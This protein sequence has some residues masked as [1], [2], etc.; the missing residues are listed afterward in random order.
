M[1]ISRSKIK[2]DFKKSHDS[3]LFDKNS[4]K[5][6]LDLMSMYSSLP[7]GYNHPIFKSEEFTSEINNIAQIKNCNCEFVSD[8]QEEFVEMFKNFINTN[9]DF[10]YD[11]FHF[12]ST[13]ALAIEFAIKAAIDISKK[14][15]G[16]IVSFK[17]SFHGI[18]AYGNIV[19][20][21]VSGTKKRLEGFFG[22]NFWPQ[23][24]SLEELENIIANNKDSISGILIEPIQCTNGDLYFPEGFLDKVFEIAAKNNILSI[25]DEIQTGFGTTGKIWFTENK[26]DIIVFGKKSQVSGFALNSDLGISLNPNRYCITWDGDLI[27]MVRCKYIIKTII[28]DNLL[29]NIIPINEYMISELNKMP[30]T[31]NPRGKGFIMA[32]DL[33][34]SIERDRLYTA[35]LSN[36]LL[37]NTAGEN[38]IRLRPNLNFSLEEA[39]EC[40]QIIKKSFNE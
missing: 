24:S 31:I 39:K 13:G 15:N 28:K 23:I 9:N 18:S 7:L 21:R 20:D 6:Y 14:E 37:L 25:V 34:N 3:Y 27:D 16:K 30:Q 40:I 32:F 26:A 10:K 4:N 29:S 38:T 1:N 36:G 5:Y 2:I 33:K 22:N 17:N 35:A 19:S 12:A 11:F 8:E